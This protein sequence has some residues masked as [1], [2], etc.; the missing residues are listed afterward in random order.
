MRQTTVLIAQLST[1]S[2]IRSP[3]SHVADQVFLSL[4]QEIESQGVSRKV[5]ADMF[6]LALRG[7]QRK[8]QRLGDIAL[9]RERTLWQAVLE[10]LDEQGPVTRARLLE[11]F[12]SS[13]DTAVLAVAADLVSG[14]LLYLPGPGGSPAY[15]VMPDAARQGFAEEDELNALSGFVWLAAFRSP[16][17]TEDEL[18][19]KVGG[20]SEPLRRALSALIDGGRIRRVSIAEGAV[21]EAEPFVI[22]VGS[23]DGWQAAVFDHFQAVTTAIASKL[24]TRGAQSSATD[25]VG[26]TTLHFGIHE[27]HPYAA[28]VLGSL[29]RTREAMEALWAKVT[30]HNVAHPVP[31]E[32]RTIV[33]FYFG[34]TA[35]RPGD[36]E[37][38]DSTGRAP[39][40]ETEEDS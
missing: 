12:A 20:P 10:F 31:E 6:G 3:L 18:L 16:R 11:R 37:E 34:Q 4:A 26:G 22:P 33:T 23:K 35:R 30:E 38:A 5:A 39:P 21:L 9:R 24:R 19:Q 27:S 17:M 2:G 40:A 14:G 36:M 32:E 29:R 25:E 28:E 15:G 13:E 8:V 1:A 7:Y